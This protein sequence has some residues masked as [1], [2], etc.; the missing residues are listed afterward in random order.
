M[1]AAGMLQ[2]NRIKHGSY[3]QV[4]VKFKTFQELLKDLPAVF[5][6][7]KIMKNINLLNEILLQECYLSRPR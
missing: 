4:C 7:F 5:K 6:D 2:V 1:H 3:R